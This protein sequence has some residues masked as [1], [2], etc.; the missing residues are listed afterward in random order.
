MS[1][2]H[3]PV[4][5]VGGGTVGLSCA[6]SL[7]RQGVPAVV[8]ER[9]GGLSIHPRATGVQPPAREFFRAV[10]L[11]EKITEASAALAPSLSKINV[12]SLT[13]DL[14]KAE[15]FPTPPPNL[16]EVTNR[17]SP[18][19]GGPCAQDQ[20]DRVLLDAA[21]DGGVSVLFNT[22]LV[23]FTQDDGGVTATLADRDGERTRT[24]RADYLI[25]ADGARSTVRDRLGIA[26]TGVER[27][28]NPMVNM[29]F[30]ADL[31]DLVR[32][33]EFAFCEIKG[34]GFEGILVAVDNADRWV[35]HVTVEDERE[36]L[37]DYPPERCR[38]LVRAAVGVPD[39][40][41]AILGRLTW[42]MS[43]RVAESMRAGRVFLAG[44]SA[45]TIPPIGAF[46]LSTG[47][48][49]GY[50]LA[51][52]LAMVLHGQAGPGL[53]DSYQ[54]ERLPI[55]QFAQHQT[56]LRFRNLHL[57]W[58]TG[59]EVERARAALRI[60]DPLV[61]GFGYQYESGAVVGA[62]KELPSL[63]HID[64]NL[65]GH[66]GTRLPHAWMERKGER[67][68]TL[69]LAGPG[70]VLLAG[71]DGHDW[72]RAAADAVRGVSLTAHRV[73]AA[74]DA[75]LVAADDS[76]LATAGVGHDGAL[77]VRPDNV[78]AWRSA[79]GVP[80]ATR[81]LRAVLAELLDLPA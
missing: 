59:P 8:V 36:S 40:D 15:R 6:V 67:V 57:Q 37:A 24:V 3:V 20:I 4:L 22:E 61:L 23:E 41:V 2:Q 33:H 48:A 19:R 46:G 44:D 30:E 25:A 17:I 7:V 70:F 72:C 11:E 16:I 13:D 39:L 29:L 71:P 12:T 26:T 55:A 32:G 60:A 53:L 58:S 42:Q 73:A 47:I 35:F 65:D 78:I 5:I 18:T 62:R 76:W 34:N 79:A 27:L 14:S 68:S 31:G 75:D 69:D 74:D 77:L 49:D 9:R 21:V 1:E 28:T 45:H 64:L 63:E 66:P 43:S 56:M 54:A 81:V 80:D 50:N 38:E 51:W 10:G 52:K